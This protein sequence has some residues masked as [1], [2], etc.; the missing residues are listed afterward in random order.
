MQ[1]ALKSTVTADSII[2]VCRGDTGGQY[3]HSS[4]GRKQHVPV[5][6]EREPTRSMEVILV[7][8]VQTELMVEICS[9]S[10]VRAIDKV[11]LM[12]FS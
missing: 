3:N 10:P 1:R 8:N 11:L 12:K 7:K 4:G 2:P 5:F 9:K 6:S